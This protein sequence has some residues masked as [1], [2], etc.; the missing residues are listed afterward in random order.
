MTRSPQKSTS[1]VA[2]EIAP[3]VYCLGPQGRTQTA[4]V[5]SHARPYAGPRFHRVRVTGLG[6]R[7]QAA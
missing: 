2:L 3:D 4:G 7:D 5:H 6:R 1:A